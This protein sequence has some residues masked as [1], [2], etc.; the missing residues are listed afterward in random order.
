[1]AEEDT[2]GEGD[3]KPAQFSFAV[4]GAETEDDF[5]DD[6]LDD[7]VA[8]KFEPLVVIAVGRVL[9]GVTRMREGLE[10]QRGV[11]ECV[12][13]AGLK[14]DEVR[15]GMFDHELS[16][17]RG[18]HETHER[19]VL[20]VWESGVWTFACGARSGGGAGVAAKSA[21]EDEDGG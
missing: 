10:E 18:V 3:T 15:H 7:G 6:E 11:V 21:V 12:A 17:R 19:A 13:E 1:T 8:E 20:G 2:V 9:V 16:E 14:L 5:G 4:F